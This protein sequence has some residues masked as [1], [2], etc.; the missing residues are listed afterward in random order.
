MKDLVQDLREWEKRET[1]F[2]RVQ[3]STTTTTTTTQT[4]FFIYIINHLL[5]EDIKLNI[6]LHSIYLLGA[7]H[8]GV[9]AGAGAS[10]RVQAL[11]QH[12]QRQS[13][14]GFLVLQFTQRHEWIVRLDLE[15]VGWCQLGIIDTGGYSCERMWQF[16]Y[17]SFSVRS[18]PGRTKQRSENIF[19][20]S[21]QSCHTSKCY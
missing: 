3:V 8:D 15:L 13:W 19:H 4:K 6:L 9:W 5:V 7:D 12:S 2:R 20:S 10:S 1:H 14:L 17:Q 16:S 21:K 11:N 18:Q